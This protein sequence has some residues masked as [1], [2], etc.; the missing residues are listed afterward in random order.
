RPPP[1]WHAT[2][3]D[4]RSRLGATPAVAI[5][6][7]DDALAAA[8]LAKGLG[9]RGLPLAPLV[10]SYI[11]ARVDRSHVAIAR[12]VDAL[13]SAALVRQQGLTIPLARTALIAC[14]FI[15]ASSDIR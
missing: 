10:A 4:L 5:G 6:D 9:A 2:L 13:D 14:G 1:L 15:D 12:V 3:P 7:P 11:L 8:L